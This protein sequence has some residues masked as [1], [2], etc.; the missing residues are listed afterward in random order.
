MGRTGVPARLF[1]CVLQ[2]GMQSRMPC[3][4]TVFYYLLAGRDTCPDRLPY[5]F[6]GKSV[7]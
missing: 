5:H 2:I 1:N 7:F 6:E 3:R 4:Y